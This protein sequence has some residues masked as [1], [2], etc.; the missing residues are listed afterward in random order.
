[1][2]QLP[3]RRSCQN[4]AERIHGQNVSRF[5]IHSRPDCDQQIERGWNRHKQE[6]TPV[7]PDSRERYKH[8][9]DQQRDGGFHQDHLWKQEPVRSDRQFPV[10]QRNPFARDLQDVRPTVEVC[11]RQQVMMRAEADGSPFDAVGNGSNVCVQRGQHRR[12]TNPRGV[13][14]SIRKPQHSIAHDGD[15]GKS[16]GETRNGAL[17]RSISFVR[18]AC[19]KPYDYNSGKDGKHEDAGLFGYQRQPNRN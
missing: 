12:S 9:Q 17:C 15:A 13:A 6:F 7:P 3:C 2:G 10:H 14:E 18:R 11:L 16:K 8:Q 4:D 1:M 19:L 5:G